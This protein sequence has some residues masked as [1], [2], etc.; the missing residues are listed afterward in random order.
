[1]LEPITLLQKWLGC[2]LENPFTVEI[3]LV[4]PTFFF[5]GGGADLHFGGAG[6]PPPPPPPTPGSYTPM[7]EDNKEQPENRF[8]GT[9]SMYTN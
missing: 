9:G 2:G 7:H 5:F 3:P 1:M 4:A 8:S 6:H